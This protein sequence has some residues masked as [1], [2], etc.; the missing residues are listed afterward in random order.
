MA[1]SAQVF[2]LK[3][4]G[5]KLA[6]LNHVSVVK[7]GSRVLPCDGPLRVRLRQLGDCKLCLDV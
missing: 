5:I 3:Q 1:S 6:A 4:S 7:F 2:G